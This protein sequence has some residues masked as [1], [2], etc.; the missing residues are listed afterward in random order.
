MFEKSYTIKGY[1]TRAEMG[2]AA[3]EDASVLI[4]SLL[5]KKKS[6]RMIFAAAPSQ[7]DFLAALTADKR[8]DFSRIHAFHMDEYIGLAPD[9]PQGFGNFLRRELFSKVS[10]AS[11]SYL[12]GTAD[13]R[14]AECRRYGELLAAAPVDIV[15]LGIGE[16]G[17]IAF[18]DP[19]AADF[20][21][22]EAV[23]VVE[24]DS[25]CRQQQVNDGCFSS[26]S[27][28]PTHALTLTVPTLLAAAHH[29]CIVPTARKAA[30]VRA[31]VFGAL[32]ESCPASALRTCQDMTLYLDRESAAGLSDRGDFAAGR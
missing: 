17:H 22:T 19:A 9:A 1:E 29:L 25:V 14:A 24:L 8:I 30:A 28:V 4:R 31:A 16:N 12:D 13:D 6:I 3:A 5:E 2:R 27:L 20:H 32:E 10:F 21:D 18:N 26:L 23:K 15:C 11:V 7:S